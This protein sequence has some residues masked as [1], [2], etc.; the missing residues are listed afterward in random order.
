MR[1]VEEDI[2]LSAQLVIR[3]TSVVEKLEKSQST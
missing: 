2:L 1:D 3:G